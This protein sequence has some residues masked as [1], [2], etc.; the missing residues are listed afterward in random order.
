MFEMTVECVED[1]LQIVEAVCL[2]TDGWTSKS[3]QSF[4]SVTA[5]FIDAKNETLFH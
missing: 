5:H 3:N 4:I 1:I 2:T